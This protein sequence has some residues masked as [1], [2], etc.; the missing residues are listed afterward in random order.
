MWGWEG[1][2]LSVCFLI[3]YMCAFHTEVICPVSFFHSIAAALIHH[4]IS[5]VVSLHIYTLV[6]VKVFCIVD[7]G[8]K[9]E[10]VKHAM[11]RMVGLLVGLKGQIKPFFRLF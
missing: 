10:M 7:T 5:T 11:P 9:L 1:V 3:S 6:K 2:P 4:G 8:D